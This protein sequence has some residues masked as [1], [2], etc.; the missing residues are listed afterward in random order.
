MHVERKLSNATSQH[1]QSERMLR[2]GN[3]VSSGLVIAIAGAWVWLFR[4]MVDYLG[5]IATREDFRTNQIALVAVLSLIGYRVWQSRKSAQ[6]NPEPQLHFP[7]LVLFAAGLAGYLLSERLLDVNTLSTVLF[8][9]ATYGLLGLWLGPTQWRHGFP[10]AL[11]LIGVLPFAEHLQTFIGYPMRIATAEVVRHSLSAAG[12]GSV[13]VDTILIF[14]NGISQVDIPCSGVKSLWTG[15]LFLIAAS[16]VDRRPITVR[17]FV[18]AGAFIGILFL[19]NLARVFALVVVG[20]VLGWRVF[21]ELIH[22]PLGILAFGAACVVAMGLLRALPQSTEHEAHAPR[23]LPTPRWLA[24]TVLIGIIVASLL[25]AQRPQTGL[26]QTPPLWQ[27]DAGL[28]VQARPLRPDEIDW[29]TRDG[30]DSAER[31]AFDWRTGRATGSMMLVPSHTWRA[32][33]RPERCFEVFGLTL[34]ESRTHMVDTDFPIRVISL[35]NPAEQSRMT[36]AYWFQARD[37]ITD[38]YGTRIWADV[39]LHPER[40]VLVTILFEQP[41]DLSAE[42]MRALFESVRETVHASFR[43]A[44]IRRLQTEEPT[45]LADSHS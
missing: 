34:N 40:W 1:L 16:W 32:H 3:V 22:V 30:A 33:H 6:L 43:P 28:Q 25:Y 41:R 37:R 15:M 39:T 21:A 38:D 2:L 29:L 35:G 14:E 31:F 44:V 20:E 7:A 36:A 17:W 11:L 18:V 45:N 27:F 24:P 8:G 4:P 26:A 23:S 5:I 10:A 9:L 12:I 19:A 13:G 42:D